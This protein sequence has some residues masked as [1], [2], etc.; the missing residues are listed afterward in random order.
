[1]YIFFFCI[2]HYYYLVFTVVYL[3]I[4]CLQKYFFWICHEFVLIHR[5]YPI[6]SQLQSLLYGALALASVL[7]HRCV[8]NMNHTQFQ[9]LVYTWYLHG[10]RTIFPIVLLK[11]KSVHRFIWTKN[12]HSSLQKQKTTRRQVRTHQLGTAGQHATSGRR[13]ANNARRNGGCPA[14]RH[15]GHRLFRNQ[16][17]VAAGLNRI[18]WYVEIY[19]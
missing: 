17:R 10:N 2:Y 7:A 6:S 3:Q 9:H 8:L 16:L 18:A 19:C 15:H 5:L 11:R 4:Y 1:M 12:R 13:M 14:H